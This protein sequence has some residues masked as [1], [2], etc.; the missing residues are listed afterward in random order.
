MNQTTPKSLEQIIEEHGHY[1]VEAFEFVRQG[2][3]QT[4]RNIHGEEGR[5]SDPRHVSGQQL[6]WGLRDFAVISY[7]VL[8][9]AVLNHWGIHRTRDFGRIVYI[10][11]AAKIMQTT[12][13]DQP[14]HF[15]NVFDFRAAFHPPEQGSCSAESAVFHL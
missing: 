11:V 2:L 8:A 6:C 1:P 12:E 9:K 5:S 15:E 10:M 4:V 14:L 13:R 3:T 7:G